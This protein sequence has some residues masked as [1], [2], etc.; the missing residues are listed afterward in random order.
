[1][2]VDKNN[3]QIIGNITYK[4]AKITF[5]R[6]NNIVHC[7]DGVKLENCEIRFTQNNSLLYIDKNEY[8]MSLNMRLGNDSVIYIG[9]DCY[10]NKTSYLYATERKNII[11]GNQ[12][13]LFFNTYFRTADPHIL[14]DCKTKQRLNPSK[15]ILIGDRVWIGKNTLILKNTII[16]SGAVIGG[17]SVITGNI[18]PS[19][20]VYA[21]NPARKVKENVF[22]G[23]H[24]ST[25]D[26]TETEELENHFFKEPNQNQYV[27][28]K[29]EHTVSSKKVDQ[30]LINLK[31]ANQKL[32]YIQK[33]MTNNNAKNRFYIQGDK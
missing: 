26:F 10:I 25:H 2:I 13:L 28:Q 33:N 15:S 5:N 22:Y 29:D 18:I 24:N 4:N 7:K 21:G 14:Y 12:L 16:G 32:E 1:M 27:Y 31:S 8:P 9:K 17:N 11:I 6:K 30:E 20:T 23:Y 19:N 3:N